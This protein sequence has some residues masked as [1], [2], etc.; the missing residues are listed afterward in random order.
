MLEPCVGA[1]GCRCR[2]RERRR[3]CSRGVSQ[4]CW[5]LDELTPLVIRL[6]CSC[7][8]RR[9]YRFFLLTMAT[10]NICAG[11]YFIMLSVLEQWALLVFKQTVGAVAVGAVAVGGVAVGGVAVGG[12]AVGEVA[13]GVAVGGVAVGEV[14]SDIWRR[15]CIRCCG[16][17]RCCGR[18]CCDRR[19]DLWRQCCIRCCGS[20]RCC[21]RR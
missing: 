10:L 17:R 4:R 12:A 15:C 13:V 16:S 20:Q 19:S 6:W 7:E 18:R 9:C 11:Y 14:V 21:G 8:R 1:V 2:S 5:V 3:C